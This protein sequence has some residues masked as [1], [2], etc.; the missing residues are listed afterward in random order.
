[1]TGLVFGC[2]PVLIPAGWVGLD[3]DNYGQRYVCRVPQDDPGFDAGEFDAVTSH[4]ALQMFTEADVPGILAELH[5]ATKPG[6]TI[7][8]GL[9]DFHRSIAAWKAGRPGYGLT[10]PPDHVPSALSLLPGE[11]D[12]ENE[13]TKFAG[14]TAAADWSLF[15]FLTWHS[16]ART[17]WSAPVAVWLLRRAGW[18]NAREVTFL[19]GDPELTQFDNRP[20][21]SFFVEATA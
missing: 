11:F 14:I 3:C 7:R 18:R 5:R 21:E 9:P 1:M 2:G 15:S 20:E 17:L 19:E 12:D 10:P 13:V 6:G 16:T 8:I 4:H